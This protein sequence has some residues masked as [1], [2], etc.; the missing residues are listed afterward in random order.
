[1]DKLSNPAHPPWCGRGPDCATAPG[2]HN[3]ALLPVASLGDEVIQVAA[4]LWQLDV[5]SPSIPV[6]GVL[7]EFTLGGD[8]ERWPIGLIQA[9]SLARLLPRLLGHANATPS[10]AA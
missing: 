1:M 10:R 7:L 5:E 4:G 9:L 3:S 6:G 8:V 2:W